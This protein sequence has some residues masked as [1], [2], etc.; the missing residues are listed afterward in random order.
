MDSEVTL[1][2]LDA[3]GPSLG[4][5]YNPAEFQSTKGFVSPWGHQVVFVRAFSSEFEEL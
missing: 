2:T 4:R 5:P 3:G 1:Q